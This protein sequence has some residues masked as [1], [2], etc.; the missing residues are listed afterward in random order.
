ME[1]L[2][3]GHQGGTRMKALAQ[4]FVWWPGLD[5]DLESVV[6]D[7]DK[8]QSTR[9]SPPQ[10][11]LHPWE[12]PAAPWERLHADFAGPFLGQMFLLV[13][14]AYSKWLEVVPISSATTNTTIERLRTIFAT[15]GLPRV[16]VT[17]NG[18]QFTSSEFRAFKRGN[19]IKHVY[20]S[21]YHP[22]TNGLAER[23]VQSFKEHMKRLPTGT[24]PEK[25]ARFLFWYRLTPH[26]TTGVPPTELLIGR[27]ARSK[28]DLLKP[29]LTEMVEAKTAMQMKHHET[30]TRARSFQVEDNVYVKDFPNS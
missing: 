20:S 5:G 28:L 19:G 15:H 14:D 25:L 21:P 22:A 1:L 13:V 18:A 26:S 27:R 7:C 11:P 24:I 12:F 30:H 17:D 16:L 6:M 2:H 23:A 8:C 3:E 10:A 9:H 29:N 4:L